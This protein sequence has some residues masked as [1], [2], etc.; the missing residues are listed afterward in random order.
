MKGCT[1]LTL[2]FD[3][4]STQ[5]TSVTR[6]HG[7]GIYGQRYFLRVIQNGILEKNNLKLSVAFDP[8]RELP[9]DIIST[10]E[11]HQ[12]EKVEVRSQ[13]QLYYAATNG[14]WDRFYTPVSG[15]I[16]ALKSLEGFKRVKL[17]A[18]VHQLRE[19]DAPA[20]PYD[21][22][23]RPQLSKR[24]Y[25]RIMDRS[26]GHVYRLRREKWQTLFDVLSKPILTVSSH[27]KYQIVTE[28]PQI[29]PDEVIV[30]DSL[31]PPSNPEIGPVEDVKEI[32]GKNIPYLVMLNA[33]RPIKNAAR[34]FA[35][36][37]KYQPRQLFGKAIVVVGIKQAQVHFLNRK[38]PNARKFIVPVEYLD[39]P[40][41][42][43]LIHD[44]VGLLYPSLS[45]GFGYPP[46]EA[47]SMGVPVLAAGVT[48][49]P[50]VVKDAALLFNPYSLG[51]ISSRINWFV[52]E[53]DLREELIQRGQIRVNFYKSREEKMLNIFSNYLT[54]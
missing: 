15:W 22:L 2:L 49:I 11:S 45:E 19:F 1:V 7:G 16:T 44:S 42:N 43:R 46:L 20:D 26:P 21:Y 4:L 13:E 41:L 6:F 30:C 23:M 29:S 34:I 28:F 52:G 50:E 36:L 33:N 35:A 8:C 37:D 12:I 53:R 54:D 48:S 51:E 18:T 24:L 27:S 47:M 3:L 25:R 32:I 40:T 31:I 10:V 5:P 39:Q 17:M 14:E 38:F 9:Q